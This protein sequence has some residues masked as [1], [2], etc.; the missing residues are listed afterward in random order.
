[1]QPRI[2]NADPAAFDPNVSQA[3]PGELVAE[4]SGVGS[5]RVGI[6]RARLGG[7]KLTDLI[8]GDVIL[9]IAVTAPAASTQRV[10]VTVTDRAANPIVAAL[11]Q[12]VAR[13]NV[14]LVAV[15]PGVVGKV[16]AAVVDSLAGGDAV[17]FLETGAAGTVDIDFVTAGVA[18]GEAYG[19]GLF[20][21]PGQDSAVLAF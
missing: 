14:P 15:S 4:N 20:P 21:G 7:Q 2:F 16:V 1:M 11:V 10:T 12:V 13:I 9:S 8:V 17:V 6:V 19:I 18:A 3:V 5:D